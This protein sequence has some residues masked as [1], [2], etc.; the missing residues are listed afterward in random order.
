MSGVKLHKTKGLNPRLTYCR[1]CGG[2]GKE[3]VL[4]GA[5]E[6]VY[7]CSHCGM[8]SIG[9]MRKACPECGHKMWNKLGPLEEHEKL[10]AS[11][12]CDKCIA[13][14]EEFK[15]IVE[16]GG[17]YWKC[18]DCGSTG[19]VKPGEFADMIREKLDIMEGPC[20]VTFNKTDCPSCSE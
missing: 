4:L 9:A 13:E 1:R 5:V 7:E 8:K 6:N 14:L 2:E 16:A 15:A 18:A 11:E 12:F 20:G 19:V 3:I 17:I 10:P